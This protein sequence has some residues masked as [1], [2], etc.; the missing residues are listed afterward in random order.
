MI[1][2]LF[3]D[4]LSTSSPLP[5]CWSAKVCESELLASACVFTLKGLPLQDCPSINRAS[6]SILPVRCTTSSHPCLF[7]PSRRIR[8]TMSLQTLSACPRTGSSYL[9]LQRAASWPA[10]A[11][12][13]LA[14]W[15]ASLPPVTV[16]ACA[17]FARAR[18]KLTCRACGPRSRPCR[19][20]SRRRGA[21]ARIAYAPGSSALS[22]A[23]CPAP[24]KTKAWLLLSFSARSGLRTLSCRSFFVPPG[25]HMPLPLS[26]LVFGA[27]LFDASSPPYLTFPLC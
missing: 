25:H 15:S 19:Q 26:T 11:K 5:G 2:P 13:L 17:G 23:D 9:Q 10:R 16:R 22:P 7:R 12:T 20:S 21:S 4:L 24:P 27:L 14:A 1:G 18:R 3:S 6:K 8:F